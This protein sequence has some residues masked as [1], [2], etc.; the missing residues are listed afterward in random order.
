MALA[1]RADRQAVRKAA[2]VN[3]NDYIGKMQAP[4]AQPTEEYLPPAVSIAPGNGALAQV[5]AFCAN[6]QRN[7]IIRS[8]EVGWLAEVMALLEHI[9]DN[10]DEADEGTGG[11]G[12]GGNAGSLLN[13]VGANYAEVSLAARRIRVSIQAQVAEL[14]ALILDKHDPLTAIANRVVIQF[15]GKPCPLSPEDGWRIDTNTYQRVS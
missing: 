11:Q 15:R 1:A 13:G 12:D 7:V 9:Q 5:R 14:R 4:I 10:G 3:P 2:A 8:A 6:P